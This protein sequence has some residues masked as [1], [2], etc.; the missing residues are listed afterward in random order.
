MQSIYW[1]WDHPPYKLNNR[2]YFRKISHRSYGIL[3]SLRPRKTAFPCTRPTDNAIAKLIFSR[4]A[5]VKRVKQFYILQ[6]IHD[7]GR[8]RSHTRS[9][10]HG[11]SPLS[12]M[13]LP[14]EILEYK[15]SILRITEWEGKAS[16]T[17]PNLN[18]FQNYPASS[19]DPTFCIWT[20][21]RRRTREGRAGTYC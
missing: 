11:K 14:K 10:L 6:T 5:N 3:I 18:F 9:L 21:C 20:T 16:K 12:A 2:Q 8:Q 17:L 1:P 19:T 7:W 13:L 4:F 15:S